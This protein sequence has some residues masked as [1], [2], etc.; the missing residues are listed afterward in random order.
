MLRSSTWLDAGGAADARTILGAVLLRSLLEGVPNPPETLVE[1]VDPDNAHLFEKRRDVILVSP[2]VMSH[3]LAH[4][5]LRPELNPVFDELF[6]AGG[7]EITLRTPAELGL[8][9][10]A[11]FPAI[12]RAA[13]AH[14]AVALG[15]LVG[16]AAHLNPPRDP[17]W[18]LGDDTRIAVIE[19]Q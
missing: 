12:Q 6:G 17:S 18:A 2:R 13:L 5:A 14:G 19:T 9:G 11:T 7:A 4:V 3:L 16:R 1:L 8:E 10:T 15:L